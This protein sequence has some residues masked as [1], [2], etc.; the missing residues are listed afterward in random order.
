[1]DRQNVRKSGTHSP[2]S[3]Q[4][5]ELRIIR[6]CVGGRWEEFGSLFSTYRDR[7]YFLALGIVK[8]GTLAADITQ[9]TFIKVFRS[10]K[11]FNQRSRFSTWVFRIAYNQAIDE[12][13]KRKRAGELESGVARETAPPSVGANPFNEVANSELQRKLAQAVEA[14][15]LKLRTAVILRYVEGLTFSEICHVT[16]CARGVLQKR[17]SRASE[18]LK[19]ILRVE[20]SEITE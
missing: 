1:M 14:L 16:G 2:M 15:P 11:W 6:A 12:Y 18:T 4:N 13:R 10:L 7:V 19:D 20:I 3:D 8:D 5:E 9:N 17:L